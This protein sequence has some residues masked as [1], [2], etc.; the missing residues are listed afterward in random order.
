MGIRENKKIRSFFMTALAGSKYSV[1]YIVDGLL[2]A[3]YTLSMGFMSLQG[4]SM[5]S[6]VAKRGVNEALRLCYFDTS[7]PDT[8]AKTIASYSPRVLVD[9][10]KDD[11]GYN[12]YTT[13][14]QA[15]NKDGVLQWRDEAKTVP[16]MEDIMKQEVN[17]KGELLWTD[18][19]KKSVAKMVP[20]TKEDKV[21]KHGSI[22]LLVKGVGLAVFALIALEAKEAL[23]RP[24]HP[25]LNGVLS[26]ISPFQVVLGKSW[27]A[28]GI[29]S[30]V[31]AVRSRV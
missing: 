28:D 15:R 24:A 1:G 3:T 17:T 10:F 8:F 19:D 21:W 5:I 2:S 11:S 31:G 23:W 27:V 20:V 4:L 6:V 18:G 22:A 29:N 16:V 13:T 7:R 25:L 12:A 14:K 9:F 26:Y 30:L